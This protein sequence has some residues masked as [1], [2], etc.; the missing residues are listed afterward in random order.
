M[1]IL[2]MLNNYLHDVATALLAASAFVLF[3]GARAFRRHPGSLQDPR[4]LDIYRHT[5][6]LAMGAL[7]WIILGG[8]VRAWAYKDFEWANAA[9]AHQVPALVAKHILMGSVVAL[10]AW[11][12]IRLRRIVRGGTAVLILA[13][14]VGGIAGC[15]GDRGTRPVARVNG[16][17]IPRRALDIHLATRT[18]QFQE[19]HRGEGTPAIREAMARRVLDELI[20]SH[21]ILQAARFQGLRLAP[22]E[23]ERMVEETGRPFPDEAVRRTLQ[24]RGLSLAELREHLEGSLLTQEFLADFGK[25][26]RA[27]EE[28]A[29]AFYRWCGSCTGQSPAASGDR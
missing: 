6:R 19:R 24:E 21:L 27:T 10:G 20:A 7:A 14:I 28:E 11:G 15:S 13:M 23:V 4:F 1:G 9:G 5:T 18:R 29:L 12:W 3:V 26:L 25:D 8:F 22:G 17:E 2:I 16:E